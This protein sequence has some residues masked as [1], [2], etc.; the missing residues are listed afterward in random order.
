MISG[1]CRWGYDDRLL[2]VMMAVEE[3]TSNITSVCDD[4]K[5]YLREEWCYGKSESE[6]TIIMWFK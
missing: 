2:F 5:D 3:F 1:N 6:W 4:G